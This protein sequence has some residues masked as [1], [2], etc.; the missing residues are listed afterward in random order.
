VRVILALLV[1]SFA[2]VA[3]G[4]LLLASSAHAQVNVT[5]GVQ[6]SFG[7]GSSPAG[8]TLMGEVGGDWLGL[9]VLGDRQLIMQW[10]VYLAVR[11]GSLGNQHPYL[12]LIG[13][14]ALSWF[15]AGWR[16]ASQKGFSPF[17]DARIGGDASVL[18]NP[19]VPRFDE[20]NSVDG[21]GSVVARGHARLGGGNAYVDDKRTVLLVAGIDEMLQA[22][23]INH[24]S[25]AFTGGFLSVR[26]DVPRS[27]TATLEGGFGGTF[28]RHD[29][30]R[31]ISDATTRAW[32][33]GS[34]RKIFKNGMWLGGAV[35]YESI[36]DHVVYEARQTTFDTAEAPHFSISLF[37]GVPIG[38]Q[39]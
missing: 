21:V 15:D 4:S 35:S 5:K 37:V 1:R 24:P 23:Q 36:M 13:P 22:A 14:H 18:G 2:L 10:D 16:F 6:A 38:G 26:V 20:I 39:R 19:D 17:I 33:G 9:R 30:L 32:I 12:F 7:F 29:V 31:G 11:G 28:A 25:Y 3:A 34:L 27:V 8:D